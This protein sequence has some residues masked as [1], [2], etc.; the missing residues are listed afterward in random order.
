MNV[1]FG[2]LIFFFY[3]VKYPISIFLPIA[4]LN[5]EY[6][7]NFIMDILWL[8]SVVLIVMDWFFPYEKPDNCSH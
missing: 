7:H 6:N 2:T 4:Y 3:F 5:L 1:I 8:I